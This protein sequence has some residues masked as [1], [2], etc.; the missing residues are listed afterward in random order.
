MILKKILCLLTALA[1]LA[2]CFSAALAEAPV[3][4]VYEI[5]EFEEFGGVYL[6]SSF[7]GFLQTG[8][9]LGDS[10]DLEFSNGFRMEDLPVYDGYYCRSGSP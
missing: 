3:S 9:H 4:A 5:R 1:L 7:E 6:I 2:V 10:C 8:F